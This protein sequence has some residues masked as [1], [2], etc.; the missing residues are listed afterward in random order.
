MREIAEMIELGVEVQVL[1]LR[2]PP[3]GASDLPEKLGFADRVRY[4]APRPSGRP[5]QVSAMAKAGL[6]LAASGR[7][8]GAAALMVEGD[9]CRANT[10]GD[11]LAL[12]NALAHLPGAPQI[13]HCHFGPVGL[14]GAALK[15]RGVFDAKL[16]TT[17]HGYDL[18]SYLNWRGLAAYDHL[19]DCGDLFFSINQLWARKL[20]ELGAPEARI[21]T[22]HMGVDCA[23]L[24][25]RPRKW[26]PGST[27]RFASVGR[28]TEKK[29]PLETLRAFAQ[30]RTAQP[31]TEMRLD[32]IGDGELMTAARQA[33]AD[34]GLEQA[35]TLHGQVQHD[36]ALALLEQAHVF[37]LHSVTAS[38]GDMEGIPVSLMEA[39]A[40]GLPVIST[41]H[42][43]IP[44]LIEDGVSGF[45]VDERDVEGM[46]AAMTKL[47]SAPESWRAITD[48]A[49][50]TVETEFDRRRETEKLLSLFEQALANKA[51]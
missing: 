37:T 41:R 8:G 45:L 48:A 51:A 42:S 32:L 44:E 33:V 16:S 19:L 20:A 23:A 50:N 38:N 34:L 13:V 27:L 21:H 11:L 25:Y 28:L 7:I 5:P 12:A 2:K 36:A 24:P 26:A 30:A 29:G 39:M 18:T 46:A 9:P 10:R 35:V 49:R 4:A 22:L 3:G 43:G 15:S 40:K 1:A 6:G 17:F 14:L 47:A 31:E